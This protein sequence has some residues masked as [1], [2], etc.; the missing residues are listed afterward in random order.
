[1]SST[2]PV[3]AEE[4]IDLRRYLDILWRRRRVVVT[5]TL[6]AVFAALLVSYLLAPIY[7]SQVLIQLSEHSASIY[8]TPSAAAQVIATPSFLENAVRT[9][10]LPEGAR[11]LRELVRVDPVRD[12][13]MI[14]LKVRHTD[15]R[16]TQKIADAIASAFLSRAAER[17]E[18]KRKATTIRLE[19]VTAQLAEF[20]RIVE[21][22]RN[23]LSRLEQ[24]GAITETD[25]GF[26]RSITLNAIS[27]SGA[28]Y[29]ELRAAQRDLTSELL[30]LELPAVVE[31]P[32]FPLEPVSPRKVM[33]T[34]LGGVLGLMAGTIAVFVIEYFQTFAQPLSSSPALPMAPNPPRPQQP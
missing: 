28:L 26:I 32:T 25:R 4:E 3:F 2:D 18:Q 24:G 17:V 6:A 23:T 15:A 34:V 27:V 21:L 31:S 33:N 13:R 19:S 5:I 29:S 16:Q 7:E 12:T 1:M 22:S 20:E 9:L 14:R 10:G 8:S 30:G 11:D